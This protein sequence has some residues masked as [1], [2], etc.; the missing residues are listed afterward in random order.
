MPPPAHPDLSIAVHQYPDAPEFWLVTHAATG[1]TLGTFCPAT[2][3][4]RVGGVTHQ[5]V[6]DP[7]AALK[8]YAAH[9]RR[10]GRGTEIRRVG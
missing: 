4:A 3:S 6:T 9:A 8:L 1:R 10:F 2:G 7:A 5:G